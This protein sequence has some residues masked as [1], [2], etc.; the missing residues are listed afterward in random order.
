MSE[1]LA[2]L[3]ERTLTAAL[4]VDRRPTE[5]ELLDRANSLRLAFPVDDDEFA[6]VIRRIESRLVIVMDTGTALAAP[7]HAPWLLNRKAGI[8]PY[9]WERYRTW[10]P[11][12]DMAPA[13]VNTLDRVTDE[14]L[15]LCGDPQLVGRWSRR[16][17]VVGDVQ[18]GKT[19]T[20]TALICKAAD[21]GYRLVILATGTLENLRRQTQER[22]DEGFV[23]LD[24]SDLLQ[25]VQIRKNRAVGVGAIDN[26][27]V[28][29][30]FT[31]RSSD[32][33]RNLLNSLGFRLDAFNEPV[34]LVIKKN[35]RVIENLYNWLRTYNAGDDDRI[36]A[37]L[38]LIDDEADSA[39]INTRDAA[40]EPTAINAKLRTLLSLFHR[41]TYV[42]FTATPFANVFVD[43][44]T[45]SAMLGDDLFPR[46]FIYSLEVPSNYVGAAA[47]FGDR[48]SMLR[49]NDDADAWYPPRHRATHVIESLPQSLMEAIRAFV[50]A[51]TIRD[52]RGDRNP[53]R[54]ML[55]NVSRFT[56][57]QNQ[58]A[59][60]IDGYVRSL[61]R[62][63]RNFSRLDGDDAL[64]NGSV[65]D[66][67]DTWFGHFQNTEFS[68]DQVR[69][70]LNDA[71]QPVTVRSVNQS[72]SASSLDY[73][74]HLPHGLRVIA[75]GG[76]SLSRG[77]T[78]EGLSTSY[79]FRNSQ[80]YDTL[81][82]MGRWFGYRDGY[83]DVCRLWLTEEAVHWYTHIWS[84]SEEL[85]SEFKRMRALA[86][87]PKDF[88]LRVR[89]HPD[90]LMVT[91]RNKMRTAQT[92]VREVSLSGNGIETARLL[93]ADRQLDANAELAARFLERLKDEGVQSEVSE[94]GSLLWRSVPKNLIAD[95]L[96]S[97]V[98]HPRNY[99]FQTD[100][101]A[102]F[103]R[104]STIDAL[105][106]WD[107]AVPQGSGQ[108]ETFGPITLRPQQRT[109]VLKRGDSSLLISGPSARVGSRGV[110]RE[111]LSREQVDEV[112][113][114]RP[115]KN[116]ADRW[117][118]LV[119]TRPLLL[120]HLVR[121]FTGHGDER[122]PFRPAPAPPMVALGLSFPVFDDSG[123]AGK[124]EYKVNMVEWRQMF[125]AEE[126]DERLGE[127]DDD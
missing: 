92:I 71:I 108:P 28:A 22:L 70:Q 26:R 15:D 76:D 21:A 105:D 29:G 43:P 9:Y 112:T 86:L 98:T 58:T 31:S 100:A 3:L 116:V 127:G 12:L 56:N 117:F 69:L 17:L 35:G 40:S 123:I 94:W 7:D 90:A 80:A 39:S 89:S 126:T 82:Q 42:G 44:E 18:S 83:A 114:A 36:S 20:Y 95:L 119:R 66:L 62:D 102:K 88:G 91:A 60:A 24:S 37:P 125:V 110:E 47:V 64:R 107:V 115:E 25:Q 61:Q 10:L 67:Y 97:Y 65:A 78:L 84:A 120:L 68:W 33:S 30:V 87:T 49:F 53:H 59:D 85:R 113:R 93:V 27:R 19:A 101:L 109:V 54:S 75:V 122:V 72:S 51:S 45:E 8:D 57:V 99:D 103:L 106:A 6:A 48:R 16:G 32:F 46:D 41:S 121:G 1:S 5:S 38:L 52:L 63:V 50:L 77:L 23:G 73:R 81:M 79:F 124:V 104:E 2:D 34:L 11:R 118:R 96:A 13:V 4:P 111:G 55:V 14:I 74:S